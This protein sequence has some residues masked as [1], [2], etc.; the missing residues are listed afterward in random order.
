MQNGG[1]TSAVYSV[2]GKRS[3]QHFGFTLV[4]MGKRCTTWISQG[5]KVGEKYVK[6][7]I[8]GVNSGMEIY[9]SGTLLSITLPSWNSVPLNQ[10]SMKFNGTKFQEERI[11]DS[12]VLVLFPFM[13]Y[14]KAVRKT[15]DL[16]HAPASQIT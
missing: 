3:C 4:R 5:E 15:N 2:C 10:N 9:Q 6:S 14:T 8:C 16:V 7:F 13:Y 11:T 12:N 1:S